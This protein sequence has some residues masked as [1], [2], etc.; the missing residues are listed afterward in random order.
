MVRDPGKTFRTARAF[1]IGETRRTIREGLS[2]RDRID[3]WKLSPTIRSSLNLNL[4]QIA[5]KANA[6][7]A[8]L[9]SAGRVVATSKKRGKQAETLT[10]IALEADTYYVRVKLQP[11]SAN[12]R[13]ALTMAAAPASDQFGNSFET[14]TP[15]RS[16]T[17]TANDFVGNSDLN[18]FLSFGTLIAGQINLNLTG[19]SD[20][21][22]LELYDG[23]RNLITT[24]NNAGTANESIN[25]RLTS[26]A[27]S[28]Y[29]VRV[30]PA[31]GKN[32]NYTFSYSF[33][34]DTPTRTASGLQY[35]DLAQG[36]G[37]TPTTGQTVTVQYTGILLDGTKF[38]SSRDRNRPFSFQIGEGDVIRGWDEGI[39]T[40]RVGGRRQLIIPAELAYG[41]RG[42]PGVIPANA[43]LIFD[44]E[45]IGIS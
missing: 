35:I 33:V 16:A 18:D 15:L 8:L 25:Q 41:S 43:P 29:Y 34:A 45:V 17:G 39:S 7:I 36:T 1:P 4:G 6:D 28:N 27:G 37:A 31:P 3:I 12:T 21:A 32:A 23:N 13:Y 2:L 38:D 14:A 10:N 44:V 11:G 22:N 24:S 26:I 40:M 19:L 9:N 20:D 30:A 5:K 42:V